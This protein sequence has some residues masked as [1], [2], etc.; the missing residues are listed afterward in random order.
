LGGSAGLTASGWL[1][2][3]G[4]R[5][6]L[7]G[8]GT[9]RNLLRLA[10]TL[11]LSSYAPAAE[12]LAKVDV[13]VSGP[14]QGFAASTVLGTAQ[15]RS[16]RAEM[17]GFNTPIEISSA[18]LTLTPEA[19]SMQKVAA[20]TG[21]THWNGDLT[22]PRPC[23]APNCVL[24]FDLSADQLSSGD[25]V[26]WF[27]PRAAKRP[28]YRLLATADQSGVSAPLTVEAKGVL[29]IGRLQLKKLL[30]SQIATQMELDRGKIKLTNL[31]A[32]LLQ[33]TH[34]GNWRIDASTLPL[35]YQAAGTL[36]NISL[37]Q[38]GALMNDAWVSGTA[39]AQFDG[40][41]SGGSFADLLSHASGNFQFIM[42]NGSLMH[43]D[44][45]GSA[46]PFP[47]HRFA[48]ELHLESGNWKLSA[49]KLE[50][51]DGIYQVSGTAPSGDGLTFLLTRSDGQSWNLTGTLAKPHL[52]RTHLLGAKPST[53]P[54]PNTRNIGPGNAPNPRRFP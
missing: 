26:E 32:Q 18:T 51:R 8:D 12:G 17:H 28:W 42:R 54:Q 31:H 52:E 3:S 25:L 19:I 48:G 4:Y 21:N 23:L 6:S 22:V 44:A 36:Q 33:G 34:Q 1:S 41:A 47:V 39:D 50:S 46:S 13:S 27:A 30:A 2:A 24:Q 15:L 9:V 37:A 11:G 43:L 10:N 40:T 20:Q 14:W 38:V 5:F 29:R 53:A 35:K 7:R 45:P 16:L 49:G